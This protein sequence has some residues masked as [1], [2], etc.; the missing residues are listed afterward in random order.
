M[1]E[2]SQFVIAYDYI[3][4][5]DTINDVVY[6]SETP[7]QSSKKYSHQYHVSISGTYSH[8][9]TT[10]STSHLSFNCRVCKVRNGSNATHFLYNTI[11]FW[12]R[13]A[14]CRYL[15][16][17]FAFVYS[18]RIKFIHTCDVSWQMKR[19]IPTE[20]KSHGSKQF[21]LCVCSDYT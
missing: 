15:R 7:E 12:V 3:V 5:Y 19:F 8:H 13:N 21:V 17:G 6:K 1:I 14:P 2:M 9:P 4:V 10:T 16:S 18:S 11:V 20:H